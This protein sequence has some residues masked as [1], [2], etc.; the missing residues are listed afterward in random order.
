MRPAFKPQTPIEPDMPK[1]AVRALVD[2]A[3]GIKRVA[4]R[5]GYQGDSQV[6]A[7]TRE[8][9]PAEMTFAQVA[10][11]TDRPSPAAAEY[12]AALAGGVFL[13]MPSSDDAI[14]RLTG[15]AM[16]EAGEAAAVLVEGLAD[17][18]TPADALAALPEV[19]DVIRTFSQL[20]SQLQLLA[21]E[22]NGAG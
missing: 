22:R 16:R 1:A 2:Q 6:Y 3:G 18:L 7:M 8:T 10:A 9:E 17:G 11:L 19:R 21:R 5:L 13:P 14:G 20:L 12:L 15:E 4:T